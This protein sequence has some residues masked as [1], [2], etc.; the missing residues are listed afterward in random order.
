MLGAGLILVGMLFSAVEAV[1]REEWLDWLRVEGAVLAL[2]LFLLG[3]IAYSPLLWAAPVPIVWY[4]AG[5]I[6][7]QRRLTGRAEPAAALGHLVQSGFE[8][9]LNS[10][11]FIRVGAFALAHAGLA[12]TV[13]KLGQA[14]DNPWLVWPTLIVGHLLVIMIEGVVVLVQT[15]RLMLFEFFIRFLRADGRVFRPL[16]APGPGIKR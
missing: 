4:L 8:L 3:A 13:V 11:S 2:Y 16:I 6:S 10:F 12:A 1:W 9:L 14:I 5:S 7:L 15:T